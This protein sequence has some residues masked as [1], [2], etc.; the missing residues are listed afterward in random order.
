[1]GDVSEVGGRGAERVPAA[2]NIVAQRHAL[3]CR[4]PCPQNRAHDCLHTSPMAT[5]PL[6]AG[7]GG[8]AQSV[9]PALQGKKLRLRTRPRAARWGR[10]CRAQCPVPPACRPCAA[11]HQPRCT[12]R[13][14]LAARPP[15][16]LHARATRTSEAAHRHARGTHMHTC[17]DVVAAGRPAHEA[18]GRRP[19]AGGRGGARG[20]VPHLTGREARKGWMGW[21][22]VGGGATRGQQWAHGRVRAHLFLG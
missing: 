12:L 15:N 5:R 20:H 13:A 7:R 9:A 1:M 6:G 8:G 22:G 17:K 14:T 2:F 19:C 21:G 18:E 10:A 3:Y 4:W 16:S 11:T